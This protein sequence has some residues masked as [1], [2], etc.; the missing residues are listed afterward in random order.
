MASRPA[1][2][3]KGAQSLTQ[4]LE[5]LRLLTESDRPLTATAIAERLGVSVSTAS[6]ALGALA[7][8]GY[9]RKPD[10]HSFAPALGVLA[11]AGNAKRQ[12]EAVMAPEAL[13]HRLADGTP[14]LRWTL[15]TLIDEQIVYLLQVDAG[16]EATGFAVGRYPLHL[17][18]IALLILL[19]RGE[20]AAVAALRASRRRYGWDRPGPTVPADETACA[21]AARALVDDGVLPLADWQK[22]GWLS[23]AT[24]VGG[25]HGQP[26]VLAIAGPLGRYPLADALGRLRAARADVAALLR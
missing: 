9:A 23:A 12:F 19:E 26:L 1:G 15:A 16:Q 21:A 10:Y 22:P 6:R 5:V 7:A 8:A 24:L 20:R 3:P 2:P 17:S 11:L 18:S 13:L 25:F 14:E 4:G